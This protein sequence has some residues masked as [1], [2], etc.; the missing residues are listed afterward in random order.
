MAERSRRR[1]GR[2]LRPGA[3]VPAPRTGRAGSSQVGKAP[4]PP[5]GGF[6][7]VAGSDSLGDPERRSRT[8]DGRAEAQGDV[9]TESR[10]LFLG[11]AARTS[12]P[13]HHP[14]TRTKEQQ[15][16]CR[17]G[18]RAAARNRPGLRTPNSQQAMPRAAEQYTAGAAGMAVSGALRAG[19]G[20][21]RAVRATERR[22]MGCGRP[23]TMSGWWWGVALQIVIEGSTFFS[24]FSILLI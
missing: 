17:S 19:R 8:H 6:G 5:R 24:F 23:S 12:T 14:R 7:A 18:V 13:H 16:I 22:Q 3:R 20:G 15:P 11:D 9:A 4:M 2:R 1:C 21:F 10:S